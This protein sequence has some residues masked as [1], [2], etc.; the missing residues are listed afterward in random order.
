MLTHWKPDI[1]TMR[2]R[3]PAREKIALTTFMAMLPFTWRTG[4]RQREQSP[5]PSIW[6]HRGAEKKQSTKKRGEK[7]ADPRHSEKGNH[8]R[9]TAGPLRTG[10]PWL[11]QIPHSAEGGKRG[12]EGWVER[13]GWGRLFC[14]ELSR[15]ARLALGQ[16]RGGTWLLRWKAAARDGG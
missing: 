11:G 7:P 14:R 6:Q 5:K 15:D 10:P 3:M 16:G 2:M 1:S 12:S 8:S 4:G 9:S 13:P